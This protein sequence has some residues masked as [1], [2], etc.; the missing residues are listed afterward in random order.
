MAPRRTV[1]PVPERSAIREIVRELD[2]C[3]EL[4]TPA[5][6]SALRRPVGIEDVAPWMRFSPGNYVRS[7]V[8]DGGRWELRLLCWQPGQTTA[9]HGHGGAGCAFRVLRGSAVETRLGSRDAVLPPRSIVEESPAELVHQVGNAGSDPLLTLHAYAPPLPVDTPSPRAGRNVVIVGG[10]AAGVAV[11]T[12]LLDQGDADLRVY[13]VERGPWLGRGVAY[14]V[15]D[16]VFRLNLPASSMSL[17]PRR[18]DDFVQWSGAEPDAFLSRATFADYVVHCFAQAVR[19][20]RAKA[21]I[22]RSEVVD[23]DEH[24]VH[25]ADGSEL[26]AEAVILA[27]GIAPRLAPSP[28]PADPRIV[29]GWDECGLATLPR[30]GRLLVLGTG[31][32]A[33]DVVAFWHAQGFEGSLTLLSRRGLLPRPHLPPRRAGAAPLAP[34]AT[35]DAPKHLRGLTRWIRATLDA[36]EARGEPWQLAVDALRP[37]IAALYRGLSAGDRARFVRSVRPY[38]DVLRHRA[39]AD[40]LSLVEALRHDGRLEVLSGSVVQCDAADDGLMVQ[41]SL[42]G[43]PSRR[44]RFDAIVRCLGPALETSEAGTRLVRAMVTTGIATPD[45]AGLGI[46]TDEQGRVVGPGGVPSDRLFALGAV[47]RASSWETTSMPEITA[48]AFEIAARIA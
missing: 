42:A 35:D 40:A 13:L 5:L 14:G 7:L 37:Q 22:V 15:D 32:S 43:A 30:R 46:V 47:R 31:L 16:P 21:R 19:K 8:A 3:E 34:E 11:A 44:E 38:W 23:I 18:P 10:G 28:L 1:P 27:T 25:L 20:S 2:R 39:P 6:A 24:S 36:H 29:D 4:T 33:L 41:L 45:P 26:K 48:H 17:D 12:H 9:L